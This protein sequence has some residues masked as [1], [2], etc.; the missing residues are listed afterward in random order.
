MTTICII[1]AKVQN[2]MNLIIRNGSP[3]DL[4]GAVLEQIQIIPIEV[5]HLDQKLALILCTPIRRK[6][7]GH[8]AIDNMSMP[9]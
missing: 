2:T 3:H 8:Q 9:R 6:F 1:V 7:A 4:V 5:T